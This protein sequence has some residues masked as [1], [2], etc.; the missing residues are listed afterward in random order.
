MEFE[1]ER[2][3][4][5]DSKPFGLNDWEIWLSFTVKGSLGWGTGVRGLLLDTLSL[6]CLIKHPGG[7]DGDT[8]LGFKGEISLEAETWV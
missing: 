1:K 2:H 4:Q 7:I 6:W 3:G 5:D 8:S